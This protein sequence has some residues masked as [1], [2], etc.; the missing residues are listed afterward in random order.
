[1]IKADKARCVRD[2]LYLRRVRA[3]SIMTTSENKM[4]FECYLEV[5]TGL[6]KILEY[7]KKE[8]ALQ[9]AIL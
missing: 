3:N 1:M 7:E 5:I 2:N 4:R 6:M 8:S 9:E